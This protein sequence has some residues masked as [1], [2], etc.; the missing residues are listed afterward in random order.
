VTTTEDD[1]PRLRPLAVGEI[2]DVAFKICFAHWK[3]L[4]KAVLIVIVPVQIVSTLLTAD[5]TIE[6]LD[7]NTSTTKTSEESLEQLNQALGGLVASSLLQVLAVTLATAACF[8]AI[9]Q[10]YLGQPT[11]WR[12]SVSYALRLLPALLLLVVLWALGIGLGTLLFIVPGIWLYIS[13]AFALP[14]LLVEGKRGPS[15][16]GRSFELVRGR[17]WKTFGVIV[18]GFLLAAIISSL[19]QVVF[20][21]GIF[22]GADN[23]AL[24]LVLSGIAGVAGL[25]ISTPFQ[26]ALLTVLY[27]DLRVR[28]EAFDLELLAQGIGASV[29]AAPPAAA[30]APGPPPPPLQPGTGSAG[31][32][33]PAPQPVLPAAGAEGASPP[34]RPSRPPPPP[35]P[36]GWGTPSAGAAVDGGDDG[37][38]E[39]PRL[40][41]VPHG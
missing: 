8:R 22:I 4:L 7:L 38:D 21:V 35:P 29:G 10:A 18:L 26:A 33:W 11:D 15:A 3:T 19:V 6:S 17:W 9:A 31:E 14:A 27:F 1:A 40:P 34:S 28:K 32:Q 30:R 12:A 24:V 13:W 5:Y 25:A 16:L 36:P 2:L 23:H 20:F 39:P 41:G 37:P